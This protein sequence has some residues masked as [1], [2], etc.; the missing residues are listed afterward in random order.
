M[1]KNCIKLIPVMLMCFCGF[2]RVLAVDNTQKVIQDDLSYTVCLHYKNRPDNQP[3]RE[4]LLTYNGK[5]DIRQA[6]LEVITTNGTETTLL[7]TARTDTLSILLPPGVGVNEDANI[8]VNVKWKKEVIS[9]VIPV[10]A[11]RHWT[12]YIYPHSHVDVGYTNTQENVEI[13]HKRNLEN[14]I[15]LAEE[16]K[17]FPEGARFL[18][19]P[20]VTWPIERY[21]NSATPAQREKLLEA[22]REGQIT[23]D[24]GYISTNT[25]ASS[26][27]ELFEFMA[28]SKKLEKMT[29]KK[30]ETMVQV[31]IPGVSWGLIPVAAQLNIPYCLSLFNGF[32]RIGL[33]HERSF[34][35]FWWLGPDGKSKVL[36][37]QPGAYNPGANIKG[38]YFWPLMAGQTD[39]TKLLQI[40][41]TDNPR[42][43]FI[44]S[45]LANKLPELEKADYYP[46]DIF[47]MTWCMADN[48]PI[49]ADLP[50]AVK[51]WNEEF[52]YPRLIICSG[53]QMMKAFEDKYGDQ[54]PVLSGD[55][56]EYWTDGQGTS[57]KQTASSRNV[58]ERVIQTETLWSMLR[59]SQPTPRAEVDETWRNIILGTEH[60]WAYMRPDQQPISDDI[61]KVKFGYFEEAEKRSEQFLTNTLPAA[62]QTS[63]TVAV[64][65][66]H[67]WQHGG[68]IT[69]SAEQSKN[70]QSIV[71]AST[72]KE[73]IS[74]RL[75]TGELAF[76]AED[77]PALGSKKYL[78]KTAKTK[79]TGSFI[80]GNT[81]DNGVV[82]I[83]IDNQT[84][85]VVNIIH[86]GKEYV[87]TGAMSSVNSYRYLK[88]DDTSGRAFKPTNNRITI[89]ED[90]PLIATILVKS[91]A[92]GCNGLTREISIIAKQPHI[93]FNNVLDKIATKQKEGVHFGFAFN[94]SDPV[95]KADI[96]WG[97][98]ELEKDQLPEANRNWIAFQ[99]WLN[100]SNN[101]QSVTWCSLDA[102]AF[103][104]GDMTANILGGA[105]NSPKW[106]RKLQPSATVY[107]WALNNH[108]HTNFALSQGGE[109][110]FRYRVL[111]HEGAFDAA[112]SNRFGM[113]QIQPLIASVVDTD[114]QSEPNLRIQGD[115]S[116]VLSVLKTITDGKSSI[117]RLRSV[118]DKDQTVSLEWKS[119]KPKSMA[120]CH[121]GEE[122]EGAT[123]VNGNSVVVPAM[124]FITLRAEW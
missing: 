33:S 115:N 5:K 58:K 27:E 37:L 8:R 73:A 88:G 64:F 11:L 124:G 71:D 62:S 65:N 109:I 35:P 46:Y 116:V 85:D 81:V 16:T 68:V 49:D 20:E 121:F 13:I 87:D 9:K 54:L 10:P 56:T 111:P 102:C 97:V 108:W 106:I 94:I 52:A 36:F 101:S 38:R 105:M 22:I 23:V 40:V 14:A 118:S 123:T 89:K 19:N 51:S 61:L 72:G 113:E 3:G 42:E 83:T 84:G 96:P 41:K 25:T 122:M 26:D 69:L 70:Y 21:M 17:D 57:A 31:D 60:T 4:I 1:K 6:E 66:T 18:W 120:I 80:K 44:D 34:K 63:S 98:M 104:S 95:V 93:E 79:H 28:Y 117:I 100:I 76:L 29:G 90:G 43:N 59:P 39:P 78:L 7:K 50:Y 110:R 77:V 30:V 99:R 32:D 86:K 15:E 53:T 75:S 45:Y 12:V 92:E 103:E 47:P 67:S 91:E 55:F 48:T 24:A 82:K 112:T 2:V 114:F 119:G 74:Q 107:S